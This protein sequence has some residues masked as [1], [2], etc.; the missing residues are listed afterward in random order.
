VVLHI[1]DIKTCG[2]LDIRMTS[3][4][5]RGAQL[6]SFPGCGHSSSV[7]LCDLLS[8]VFPS[9]SY[10]LQGFPSVSSPINAL[11]VSQ[12]QSVGSK[13]GL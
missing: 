6:M 12:V 7:V 11:L 4:R 2:S 8:R 3:R 10:C 5:H 1:S 9:H 13:V